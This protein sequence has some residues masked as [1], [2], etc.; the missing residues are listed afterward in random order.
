[1]DIADDEYIFFLSPSQQASDIIDSPTSAEWLKYAITEWAETRVNKYVPLV[2]YLISHNRGNKFLLAKGNEDV[3]LTPEMLDE[4]LSVLPQDTPV[5]II[6]EACYA[7]NFIRKMPK[8]GR[9]IITSASEEERAVLLKNNSSFSKY[10]FDSVKKN[11]DILTAFFEAT[12]MISHIPQH[13]HQKPQ[14]DA[15]GNGISNEEIDYELLRKTREID[16]R[17]YIP[18][19][20][21]CAGE[22]PEIEWVKCEPETLKAGE[23]RATI[24]AKISGLDVSDIVA[25]ITPPVYDESHLESSY[26]ESELLNKGG[27]LYETEYDKFS[28]PGNYTIVVNATNPEGN[29][30]PK[31][32]ILTV[33]GEKACP[34][35]VNG[36]GEVD[37]SDLVLVGI[38]LGKSDANIKGDVNGDNTVDII[39]LILVGRHFGEVC[40]M[41]VD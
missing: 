32:A 5:I 18:D 12:E 1:L 22:P 24:K 8:F 31:I 2:I 19:E 7:G 11:R 23:T 40:N 27:S 34:W 14:L 13:R 15:N 9:T 6:I 25:T 29:A 30:M 21:T 38:N 36:D 17:I 20:F 41:R 39:D 3:Y 16:R 28:L 37:I 26:D 10:F 35:D 33:E 4:W